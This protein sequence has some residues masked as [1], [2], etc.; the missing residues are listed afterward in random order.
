MALKTTI[1]AKE[2]IQQYTLA[3][4]THFNSII[5]F[6]HSVNKTQF[7]FLLF[8]LAISY[9]GNTQCTINGTTVDSRTV[10]CSSLSGCTIVYIGDGVSP[11][12]LVMY[13]NLDLTCLGAIQLIIRNNANIDFSNGNYDLRLGAN[14]S[15][16]VEN[17]GNISA[18]SNCSSSDLIWIGGEK[19]AS[20]TGAGPSVIS[21]PNLVMGGGYNTV[22][23]TSTIICGS[24]TSTIT[25]IRNPTPTSTTTYNLYTDATEG[26]AIQ[27]IT[28]SSPYVATF[29]TPII[30]STTNYFINAT[31]SG[32]TTLRRQ[33]TVTV[34][35]I[36]TI[37]ETSPNSRCGTGTVTL[38]A[39]TSAGTINWYATSTGGSSLGTGT[40]FTT[41]SI[42]ATTTY[43]VDA[44][45]NGCTTGTRTAVIA[46]VNPTNTWNGSVSTDWNNHSNWSCGVPTPNSD[47]LIP[48]G[49][50]LHPTLNID[51]TL[52]NIEIQNGALLNVLNNGLTITGILTLNGKI[53]LQNE[54]QL[55]QTEGS[56][57][58]SDCTTGKIEIDQQ[59]V[60][61]SYSYNYWGSPVN[62]TCAAS[63]TSNNISS[64]LKDSSFPDNIKSFLYGSSA[65]Y[66]DSKST[67]LNDGTPNLKLSTYWMYKFAN[68]P[69]GDY[70]SWTHIRNTGQLLAGEGFTLKGSNSDFPNQNYT[71]VGKPNNGLIELTVDQGMQYLIGNP[72]PSAI[73]AR[74][75]IKDNILQYIGT[76]S[77]HIGR[78]SENI[79]DGNLYFWDH[80]GFSTH[81]LKSYQGGYAIYNLSGEVAFQ[82]GGIPSPPGSSTPRQFIPV[83]QGFFVNGLTNSG[84]IQFKNNQ[85][86]YQKEENGISE[87]IRTSDKNSSKNQSSEIDLIKRIY[88][89]F[90]SPSGFQRQILAAFIP[91]TT[92]GI[93]IGYDAI[94]NEKFA[95][96]MSWVNA[97]NK[98]VI[99]A[100]PTFENR[101]LPLEVKVSIKGIS[102]ISINLIENIPTETSIL[103]KD[104]I[105][106][107][108]Y[109][110]KTAPFEI[111]LSP[112]IYTNRF[113]LVLQT[114]KTLAIDEENIVDNS[115]NIHLN[116]TENTIFIN[117][118]NL[119][120]IK[121]ISIHNMLGQQLSSIKKGLE[122]QIVKIPLNVQNGVY[123]VNVTTDKGSVSKK[124]IKF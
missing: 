74:E 64:F 13:Q 112:G 81:L 58:I 9:K 2:I 100:V 5:V 89:K 85:R 90:N 24:G 28:T 115:I 3:F 55:I 25:A 57:L 1:I 21:F 105:S 106:G 35:P 14:S 123:I 16:I 108:L 70:N 121:E 110:L 27:T 79:I 120:E 36:P 47:I 96:D 49:I 53:D 92:E 77:T 76:D 6:K 15:I 111:N 119:F 41:P 56:L 17:G 71:F 80:Y 8:I 30:S 19:V 22:N 61:D 42:A 88:L 84:K 104:N 72:Y 75:F 62:S 99:Q 86:F 95:E 10:T 31:T 66:A 109:N 39:T 7:I 60:A 83:A 54:S 91:K 101:V 44:T 63:S 37:T 114:Q 116:N 97:E 46:T 38:G 40:S 33:V 98:F 94:N 69:A 51:L 82:R 122:H 23:A 113:E 68:K 26:T 11:T 50:T 102:T 65:Y 87:F 103:I 93:D 117:N 118:S 73:D 43:Y 34:V 20:C 12:S 4:T 29:I 59:G 107:M 78:R 48:S 18:G 67:P 45:N 52:R 32:I 124:I